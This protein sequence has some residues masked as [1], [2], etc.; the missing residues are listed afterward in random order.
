MF[1]EVQLID[2]T[3]KVL[4]V[5]RDK[6]GPFVVN[7]VKSLV[8]AQYPDMRISES[9][10]AKELRRMAVAGLLKSDPKGYFPVLT[11]PTYGD[12]FKVATEE[13]CPTDVKVLLQDMLAAVVDKVIP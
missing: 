1:R 4:R 5:L 13:Q 3:I 2:H 8:L 10:L 6:T 12:V 11:A 7:D 9:Y